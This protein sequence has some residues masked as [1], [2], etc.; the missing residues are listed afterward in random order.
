M[1]TWQLMN[2]VCYVIPTTLTCLFAFSLN[3]AASVNAD[4]PVA[5]SPVAGSVATDLQAIRSI[6]AEGK[7]FPAAQ[8]SASRLSRLSSSEISSVWEAMRDAHPVSQNWLRGIAGNIVAKSGAP[9]TADLERYITDTTHSP[10]GRAAAMVVLKNESP[11]RF[12]QQLE[13]SL[14][15]PSL[16]IREMAIA[17]QLQI[18]QSITDDQPEVAKATLRKTLEAARHPVQLASI[19]K[20]L[21]DLG[22]SIT[23]AEAFAMIESWQITGPF[24]NVAGVG[25]DTAYPPETEFV[26]N[27]R[28]RGIDLTRTHEGKNGSV[29]WI[30]IRATGDE[31]K[32]DLAAAYDKEKGAVAYAYAEFSSDSDREAQIRL[33]CIC[34]NQVWLN[35]KQVMSNEVYHSGSMIDQ[36]TAKVQLEKGINRI[37][38][39]I[40]QNEQTQSWAQD[41]E[42]Q[43]RVTDPTGKGLRPDATK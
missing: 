18:V 5:E 1:K 39:K 26:A 22:D 36:Y 12:E 25:F 29:A 41:W 13:K 4:S 8:D 34:A 33:G 19:L 24:D 28:N 23:T 7:G 20:R 38:L 43:C 15:D 9:S 14:N 40:C 2:S 11:E 27:G 21:K 6:E 37:L 35:G 32:I 16:L 30:P 10:E 31:G 17:R 42:F 3:W